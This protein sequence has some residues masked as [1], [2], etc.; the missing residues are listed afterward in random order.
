MLSERGRQE[1]AS[2][3]VVWSGSRVRDDGRQ[4]RAVRWSLAMGSR[5]L[6]DVRIPRIDVVGLKRLP[7]SAERL[8]RLLMP[9]RTE[10]LLTAEW[11]RRT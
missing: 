9:K 5:R 4:P 7:F 8:S 10:M 11:R 6:E 3:L 2:F 1:R